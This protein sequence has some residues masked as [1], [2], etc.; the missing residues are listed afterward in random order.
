[1]EMRMLQLDPTANM[2]Q[3]GSSVLRAIQN[4]SYPL[5]DLFVRESIQNSLDAGDK[6]IPIPYVD[7]EFLIKEFKARELNA[8]LSDISDRL[9]DRFKEESY[10]YIAVKDTNTT[11][12]TGPLKRSEVR[13]N[14]YGNLQ[15]LVYHVGKPQEDLGAGGSWGYGKTLYYR[16]SKIGLVVYYS[17][18]KKE[19]GE[20]EAR[21]CAVICENEKSRDAILP[22][23]DKN[24]NKSGIAWWGEVEGSD[25]FPITEEDQICKFLKIFDIKPYT[26]DEV[27][28]IVIIPYI[29]E[30]ALG[31]D[32][33]D[34]G[35][36]F[37]DDSFLNK[38]SLEEELKLAIQRWYSP[39]LDNRQYQIHHNK[40]KKG[41]KYLRAYI[42]GEEITIDSMHPVFQCIQKL[43]NSAIMHIDG[44]DASNERILTKIIQYYQR[45]VGVLSCTTVKKEDLILGSTSPYSFFNI[46]KENGQGNIPIVCMTRLPG[47]IV[48]YNPSTWSN[49][50][51]AQ[52]DDYIF[53]MFVL[54]SGQTLNIKGGLQIDLEEYIRQSEN[55]DHLGWQDHVIKD[56]THVKDNPLRINCVGKII[57]Q[58]CNILNEIFSV[59]EKNEEANSLSGLSSLLGKILS[60]HPTK[61]GTSGGH[62]HT[63]DTPK[64]DNGIKYT[65]GDD[66]S[67]S[68]TC[69]SFNVR[70]M[71][72]KEISKTT[73]LL[74]TMVDSTFINCDNW[75]QETGLVTP[76]SIKDYVINNFQSVNDSF[77]ISLKKTTKHGETYGIRFSSRDKQKHI[78]WA[79]ITIT[80]SLK[81][82]D[83]RPNI[84]F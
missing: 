29:D 37:D 9:N 73:L 75:E 82:K 77:E 53:A 81:R 49:L 70:A 31:K 17:R 20:F 59:K 54:N 10:K 30:Q 32:I 67:Y 66:I 19:N 44:K 41:V 6:E 39:R 58:C 42:N 76:F 65:I 16:I 38:L 7:V 24:N 8:S 36:D 84:K 55:A 23:Y 14:K 45:D 40:N 5:I 12:L 28:T 46:E 71:S 43:Y 18:I 48:Q 25:T 15:K 80:I 27:G 21:L 11:G 52:N 79:D 50:P 34:Q 68:E 78:F 47:M 1:M 3:I 56:D 60:I 63:K 35:F 13:D 4:N 51:L 57:A 83:L 64:E 26:R 69:I 22:P 74:G 2:G 62:S 72:K 33:I 61:K